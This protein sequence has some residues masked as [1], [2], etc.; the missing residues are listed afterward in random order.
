MSDIRISERTL[1]AI[2]LLLWMRTPSPDFVNRTSD[3]IISG[4][5]GIFYDVPPESRQ[6]WH[7]SSFIARPIQVDGGLK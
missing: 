6:P 2:F 1:I 3:E 7:D 5:S 4:I